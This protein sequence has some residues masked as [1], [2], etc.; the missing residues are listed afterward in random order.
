M[1]VLTVRKQT[2]AFS[3][4]VDGLAKKTL[5]SQYITVPFKTLSVG[6]FFA[7]NTNRTLN[8]EFFVSPDASAPTAKPLTGTNV[9]AALGHVGYIAGEAERRK[10]S[11]EI[12][13]FSAGQYLKVFADNTDTFPHTIDAEIEIELIYEEPE[14]VEVV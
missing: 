6:A 1:P 2:I 11:A 8:L 4:S 7:P 14:K 10:V 12:G 9:L 5:V 13:P 3:G